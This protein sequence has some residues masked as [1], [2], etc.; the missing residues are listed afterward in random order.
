MAYTVNQLARLAGVSVRTLHHYDQIGLLSPSYIKENGY[1]YYEKKELARLQQILFFREL[2]FPLGQIK[3]MLDAPNFNALQAMKDQKKLLE[4]EKKRVDG[5]IRTISNSIESMKQNKQQDDEEMFGGL[6]R[7]Q[8]EEYKE[9]ARQRW[10]GTEA[11]KQSQERTKHWTKE[12]YNRI[13][14]E[15]DAFFTGIV[16][17]MDK[18]PTSQEA[19]E[20]MEEFF[21]SMQQFYDCSYE[22]FRGLGQMYVAD[23]R[24]TATF[25]KYDT[26]LAVFMR[27]A[28]AYYSDVHE[29]AER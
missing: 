13:A 15:Q 16:A 3:Q 20:K 23:K 24:F 10:G 2:E 26:R 21:Q 8:M 17:I 9:E 18:G 12:D 14:K 22:I 11:W 29:K 28:M 7:K 1:R 4:M 6:T 19:Q 5:L 25:D 27:D